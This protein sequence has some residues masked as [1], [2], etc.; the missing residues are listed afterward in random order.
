MKNRSSPVVVLVHSC[1]CPLWQ[2]EEKEDKAYTIWCTMGSIPHGLCTFECLESL[3]I[4]ASQR[5]AILAIIVYCKV[6]YWLR[7]QTQKK[8][9]LGCMSSLI[10]KNPRNL[11]L[12]TR[13][14]GSVL[15]A[16]PSNRQA[17]VVCL[18]RAEVQRL[19][20]AA[21]VIAAVK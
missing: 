11:N 6:Q 21:E 14:T 10:A 9:C 12:T 5:N 13:E 16:E 8:N 15:R 17:S 2:L 7:Y 18:S 4:G 19:R 3:P 20:D 1:V